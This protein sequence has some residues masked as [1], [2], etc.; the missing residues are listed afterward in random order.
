MTSAPLS[1]P[2]HRAPRRRGLALFGFLPIL[3]IAASGCG[4]GD[5][6]ATTTPEPSKL[7][8]GAQNTANVKKVVKTPSGPA[9]GVD[10]WFV[11]TSLPQDAVAIQLA[12]QASK[13]AKHA[14]L[15][16]VASNVVSTRS[17]QIR[18]LQ[19]Q[20]KQFQKSGVPIALLTNKSLVKAAEAP[21]TVTATGAAYD[22]A[23]LKA[24][25]KQNAGT[26]AVAG[27]ELRRG[28]NPV[29][30]RAA[31]ALLAAQAAESAKLKAYLQQWYG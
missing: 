25:L 24:M 1:R 27:V 29:I 13:L 10:N 7:I 18:T 19:D 6:A 16:A 4:G 23:Y 26:A 28:S 9:S 30:K 8:T 11:L 22:E 21:A 3:A 12:T 14:Q 20:A 31:K 5:K 17:A 2:P 15:K